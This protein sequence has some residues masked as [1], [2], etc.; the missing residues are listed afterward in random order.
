MRSTRNMIPKIFY[1]LGTDGKTPVMVPD[2]LNWVVY[3]E[4]TP[5]QAMVIGQDEIGGYSVSTVFTGVDLGLPHRLPVL[6]ETM[7][8]DLEDGRIAFD[9]YQERY[10]TWEEAV[11]GHREA[12]TMVR[13]FVS[14]L[15]V[16]PT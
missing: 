15:G 11:A 14:G 12:V 2:I 9:G 5:E 3:M 13:D 8:F 6:F 10:A 7:I 16:S 4:N 1:V